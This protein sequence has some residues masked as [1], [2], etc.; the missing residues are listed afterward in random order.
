MPFFTM[1][2]DPVC[3][4]PHNFNVFLHTVTSNESVCKVPA[5]QNTMLKH[6]SCPHARILQFLTPNNSEPTPSLY[7]TR[8]QHQDG[9]ISL[10]QAIACAIQHGNQRF[11]QR[12]HRSV[13]RFAVYVRQIICTPS[14]RVQITKS[15]PVCWRFKCPRVATAPNGLIRHRVFKLLLLS[16]KSYYNTTKVEVYRWVWV[17]IRKGG[18][19]VISLA[20]KVFWSMSGTSQSGGQGGGCSRTHR[21][22]RVGLTKNP[23]GTRVVV[24]THLTSS[25]VRNRRSS[26]PGH[27]PLRKPP[28]L[29]LHT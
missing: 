6:E 17:P 7:P 27:S 26:P 3:L 29:S 2:K 21:L 13:L 4:L 25:T 12:R 23:P 14:S 8:G 11:Q 22:P 9:L 18:L 19:T 1:S 5:P 20:S 10:Q 28:L 15:I 24:T 16:V